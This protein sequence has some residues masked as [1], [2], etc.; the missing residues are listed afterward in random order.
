MKKENMFISFFFIKN[1]QVGP[2]YEPKKEYVKV[3]SKMTKRGKG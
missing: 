2:G 1:V 3:A